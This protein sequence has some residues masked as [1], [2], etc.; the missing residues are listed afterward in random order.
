MSLE[1]SEPIAAFFKAYREVDLPA[2]ARLFE[3]NA[4]VRVEDRDY[5]GIAVIRDWVEETTR[6]YHPKIEPKS[7]TDASRRTIVSS[8]VSGDF[9]GSPA[10]LDYVFTLSGKKISRLEIG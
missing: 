1:L 8:L 5:G 7:T 10:T 3:E 9:P 4:V 2:I 6:R